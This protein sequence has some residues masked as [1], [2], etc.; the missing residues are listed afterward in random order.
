MTTSH[1][2]PVMDLNDGTR[3]PQLGFGVFQ[4]KPEDT[5]A[6]V[7]TALETGYRH[8]DTA[9]MYGNEAE[10]GHAIAESGI[11]REEIWVTSKLSN[12]FHD[13]DK[14]REEGQRSAEKLGDVMDLFLIHWPLSMLSDPVRT[15]EAMHALKQHGLTRSI[16]VSNFQIHHLQALEEAGTPRPSVNQIELHPY[17]VQ[18]ELSAYCTEHDI[19]V[20]AWSPIAQGKVL[21]DGSLKEIAE[22]HG[23]STAQVTLRW[24]IQLDHIVF[25]KSSTPARMKENFEIFDFA[26]SDEELATISGL[27]RGERIGPDPDTFDMVP[28][29]SS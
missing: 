29:G 28:S 23:K 18:S 25:P 20:E 21:D 19:A 1:T 26:L 10:V 16:G 2:V 13:P 8:I 15:W 6:A 4:I 7:L 17:L 5:K 3:I 11:P 27:N 12:A 22:R 9:E 24:H 14:V